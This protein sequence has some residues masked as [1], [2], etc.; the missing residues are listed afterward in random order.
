MI[1]SVIPETYVPVVVRLNHDERLAGH[2]GNERTLLVA[3]RKYYWPTM[4]ID[5][6]AYV[7]RCVKRGQHIG[8]NGPSRSKRVLMDGIGK[9]TCYLERQWMRM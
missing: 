2:P 6:D 3:R 8:L 1:Q 7:A 5:I 9:H 4:R